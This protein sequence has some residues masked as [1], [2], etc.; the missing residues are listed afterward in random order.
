MY[1]YTELIVRTSLIVLY[2]LIR[3]TV[4]FFRGDSFEPVLSDI[5][6]LMGLFPYVPAEYP[7]E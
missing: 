4:S 3:S 6:G 1:N 2:V 5:S 7:L